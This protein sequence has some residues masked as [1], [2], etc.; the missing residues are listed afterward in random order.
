MANSNEPMTTEDRII[1][2]ARRDKLAVTTAN[3][4][5]SLSQSMM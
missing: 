2:K 3:N 4:D 5:L 1:L